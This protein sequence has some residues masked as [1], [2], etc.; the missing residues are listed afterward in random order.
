MRYD[1]AMSYWG[2]KKS[3]ADLEDFGT[4]IGE[5]ASRARNFNLLPTHV[6]IILSPNAGCFTRTSM[7]RE[8]LIALRTILLDTSREMLPNPLCRISTHIA[9]HKG[10]PYEIAA[11]V[12]ES[13][14]RFD[15]RG[16]KKEETFILT[17]GGDG[18]HLEALSALMELP[19]DLLERVTVFRFPLGTGNDGADADSVVTAARVLLEGG[20][21]RGIGAIHV[22][23]RDL[24]PFYAFNIAS[25]G[26]D[27]FV[28]GITNR[29][30]GRLSGDV[31][32][33]IADASTLFY[34]TLYGVHPMRLAVHN[35]GRAAVNL[36]GRYILAALGVSGNRSYGDHKKILPDANN[37]C[38]IL[39]RSFSEKLALKGL[40]F[41]GKHLGA[42]GVVSLP[43]ERIIVDY[44]GR[45]PVQTDGEARF[46]GPE[47]F[48]CELEI[49]PPR[50]KTLQPKT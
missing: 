30:K 28:T 37:L 41:Q 24:K 42:A 1:P 6:H 43:A 17:L 32:K 3:C 35:G 29:L 5:I 34:E 18:T 12:A 26:I 23:P 20:A 49:L 39:T 45:L 33:L 11:A 2:R 44:P 31:Y 46:L 4:V 48:P 7:V 40:I 22:R 14:I 38:A 9:R 19:E 27:A 15:A 36:E 16:E 25:F 21:V 8:N 13:L 10:H 47:N 50:I